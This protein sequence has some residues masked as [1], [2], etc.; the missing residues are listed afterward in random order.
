MNKDVL[1]A[2]M[3]WAIARDLM[4]SPVAW[5]T[6]LFLQDVEKSKRSVEQF[7]DIVIED[8]MNDIRKFNISYGKYDDR[9]LNYKRS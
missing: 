2:L 6:G 4:D 3:V 7:S 8:A 5:V 1:L 9:I